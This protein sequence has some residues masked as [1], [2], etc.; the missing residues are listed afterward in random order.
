MVHRSSVYFV[1]MIALVTLSLSAC[2]EQGGSKGK[3]GFGGNGRGEGRGQRQALNVR[4]TTVQ[5]ISVQRSVDLSGTLISPDQA[6][7]SSE[8]AGVVREVLFEIGQEVNLAQELVRL[9][10]TELTLALERAESA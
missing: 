2:S 9:D 8:V 10:T 1:G 6:K 4:T 7:V 3:K 5:K